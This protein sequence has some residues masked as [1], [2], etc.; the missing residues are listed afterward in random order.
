MVGKRDRWREG[1][2]MRRRKAGR[3]TRR[4]ELKEGRKARREAKW[5]TRR[6]AM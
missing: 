2:S 1:R 3:E 5:K 4:V 6:G